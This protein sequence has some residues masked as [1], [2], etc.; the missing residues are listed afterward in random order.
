[1]TLRGTDPESYITEYTLVYED[2]NFYLEAKARIC[3]CLSYVCHLRSTAVIR[4]RTPMREY[5]V[6]RARLSGEVSFCFAVGV[7]V[8]LNPTTGASNG[9]FQ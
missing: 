2:E 5:E 1:M 7:G 8:P 6:I 3:P 9:L 4:K